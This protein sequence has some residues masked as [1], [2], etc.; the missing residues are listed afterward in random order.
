MRDALAALPA[1]GTGRLA[2]RALS[3]RHR[4]QALY[5]AHPLPRA[6]PPD[7]L[8]A[9]CEE[10]RRD[11][12]CRRT[13]LAILRAAAVTGGRMGR[14]PGRSA[15]H[16][17]GVAGR[18]G[19]PEGGAERRAALPAARARRTGGALAGGCRRAHAARLPSYGLQRLL[20]EGGH[21]RPGA[22]PRG[23]G[24]A[25][26]ARST[27]P[28]SP[29]RCDDCWRRGRWRWSATAPAPRGGGWAR[30]STGTTPSFA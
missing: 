24:R 21:R 2:R 8:R 11:P 17:G 6:Q 7:V 16:A 10:L 13:A 4:G 26:G 1:R 3:G 23:A 29:R 15:G 12:A 14:A 30:R 19:R 5:P 22:A 25:H 18:R 27:P 9:S 28:P 20:A